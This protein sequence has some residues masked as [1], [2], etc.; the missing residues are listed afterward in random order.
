MLDGDKFKMIFN[1]SLNQV[2]PT[3]GVTFFL[4]KNNPQLSYDNWTGNIAY[5]RTWTVPVT[6]GD[7]QTSF[8]F[9]RTID[10]NCD[11]LFPGD[12]V[13]LKAYGDTYT[14]FGN[15]YID[16]KTGLLVFPS[17]NATASSSTISFIV[18]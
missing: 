13:F 3:N 9:K 7:N 10:C 1:V 14:D 16:A 5:S 6:S 17:I 4:S 18:P 8:C 11:F 2:K 15:S 12:T